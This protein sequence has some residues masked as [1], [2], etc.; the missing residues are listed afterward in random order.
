MPKDK[1]RGTVWCVVIGLGACCL[2]G[3]LA[4]ANFVS[5]DAAEI[6]ALGSFLLVIGGL[7]FGI[8][9]LVELFSIRPALA[10]I[11]RRLSSL[12][13]SQGSDPAAGAPKAA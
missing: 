11:D 7:L 9:V 10:R 4:R 12:H 1:T 3:L 8:S 2:G 13:E 5:P 6:G